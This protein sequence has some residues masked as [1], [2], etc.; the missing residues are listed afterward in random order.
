ML[1]PELLEKAN[2][3]FQSDDITQAMSYLKDAGLQGEKNAALDYAY[4]TMHNSPELTI[5]YLNQIPGAEE[6]VVRYHKLLIGYF[7][8]AIVDSREVAN[9]LISLGKEG[10]VQALLTILSYL[11]TSHSHFNTVG[12]WLNKVSPNICSQLKIASFYIQN[13]ENSKDSEIVECLERAL[14]FEALPSEVIE[15]SLPIIEYKGIL[16]PFECSYLMARF[17]TLLKPSMI[18]D[19]D[20]GQGRYDSVRTS[21]VA[22]ITADLCDWIIR[23]IDL[24]IAR[25]SN[26]MANQGE[27]L[28]LLRYAPGQ[29]YKGHFDAISVKQNYAIYQDGAQRIKTA[30]IYLNSVEDGGKTLFPRLD[31]AIKPIQGNMII[32]DNVEL[33]G[34]VKPLSF[35]AGE[36]TISSHKWLLT[37]WIREG[38]TNYGKLVHGT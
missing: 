35:H 18:V 12:K 22:P 34:R 7:N 3:A 17:E 16:S 20:S 28:N 38:A 13:S 37:K 1:I 29:E 11:P 2:E 5:E 4:F 32:F 27:Y 10:N 25:H 33:N 6:Q 36:S 30:L 8:G 15:D 26:T 21:Y 24:S 19:P 31:L 14:Q 23:K 9:T